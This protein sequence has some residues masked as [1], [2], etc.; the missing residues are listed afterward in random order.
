MDSVLETLHNLVKTSNRLT[1]LIKICGKLQENAVENAYLLE[2]R[3][4]EIKTVSQGFPCSELKQSLSSWIE[5]AEADVT[6]AKEDFKFQFAQH[7]Q[8][9]LK[10]DGKTMRGHFPLLR[11]GLYTLRVNF[12][13]GEAALFFGPE[14]EKIGLKIAFTPQSIYEALKRFDD[15]LRTIKESPHELYEKL[16]TAY[17]HRLAVTNKQYG[18]KLLVTEVLHEFA[19]LQQ[20][21]KFLADPQKSNFREY[22][23]VQLSYMLYYLKKSN[24]V[25]DMHVHVATFDATTDKHHSIWVPH[26]EQG[27]GTYYAY[28]S[29][30]NTDIK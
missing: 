24:A 21:K 13:L 1:K 25:H 12:D 2:K 6:K 15:S 23:R 18:E 22:S 27:E 14:V 29:F 3:L 5:R 16:R 20:S 9:L 28:I 10:Q 4:A 17:K 7:L 11:I 26:N 8:T 19:M 30:E